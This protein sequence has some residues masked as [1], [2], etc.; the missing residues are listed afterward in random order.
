MGKVPCMPAPPNGE[1]VR[2]L[3]RGSFISSAR[4]TPFAASR[5]LMRCR[6]PP[7]QRYK[8]PG[9]AYDPAKIALERYQAKLAG[10]KAPAP[11][12]AA[13]E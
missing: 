5:A 3:L 6:P 13:A 1:P 9:S 4:L 10:A 11:P 8:M 12:A 7:A 2:P